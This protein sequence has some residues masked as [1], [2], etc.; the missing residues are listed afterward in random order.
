MPDAIAALIETVEGYREK[1]AAFTE[2]LVSIPTENPPGN[3]Y[4][5]A[6]QLLQSHLQQLGFINT[7]VA[8]DC[9]LSFAG[10]GPRTLYFSG[11]YDVVP[12]Q[13][14]AQFHPERRGGNIFGRGTGDMKGGLAAMIYAAKGVR[15]SQ[16]PLN[17]RIG[18]VFVPDEETAG[19]RGSRY[20]VEQNILGQNGI[21]MLTP[22]PTGGVI[23]N[24]NRGALSLRVSVKGKSAHVGRQREGVNAFEQMLRVAK[25]LTELK[26]EVEQPR[27]SGLFR[28]WRRCALTVSIWKSTYCKKAAPAA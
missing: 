17:G 14:P 10:E 7:R 27:S 19:E 16:L 11:H 25:A 18:L 15:D 23:W 20:L 9:V 24:A 1:I 3:C 12:A 13:S 4:G 8:G 6:V 5:R 21:G 22:E 26:G 2:Q 28:R